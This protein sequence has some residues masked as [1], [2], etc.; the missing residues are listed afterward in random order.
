MN[1]LQGKERN[2]LLV[3]GLAMICKGLKMCSTVLIKNSAVLKVPHESE[4]AYAFLFYKWYIQWHEPWKSGKISQFLKTE[5]PY[6][7]LSFFLLSY[8]VI[9]LRLCTDV[10][11]QAFTNAQFYICRF[12]LGLYGLLPKGRVIDHSLWEKFTVSCKL[13]TGPITVE[14]V[15]FL[16]W[17]DPGSA[18]WQ[19]QT[20]MHKAFSWLEGEAAC[21]LYL[22][23]TWLNTWTF[24][25]GGRNS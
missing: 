8:N 21:F 25:L 23:F 13:K 6:L 9:S 4:F 14:V 12:F 20:R 2:W 18:G 1:N 19:T 3:A 5:K 24:Q 16:C 17:K 10:N 7:S 15:L 22:L 11:V